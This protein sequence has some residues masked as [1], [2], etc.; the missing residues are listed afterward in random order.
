MVSALLSSSIP[1]GECCCVNKGILYILYRII[2]HSSRCAGLCVYLFDS[3][4]CACVEVRVGHFRQDQVFLS[5]QD[6][7]GLSC[8]NLF[9][10]TEQRQRIMSFHILSPDGLVHPKM[11][12]S[13][14]CHNFLTNLYDFLHSLQHER[15]NLEKSTSPSSTEI[16]K[17]NLQSKTRY[18]E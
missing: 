1:P 11:N 18:Y 3:E 13:V 4:Q 9:K 6:V 10:Y 7:S 12:H 8:Q 14:I 17:R 15:R 2:F 16:Q 5:F